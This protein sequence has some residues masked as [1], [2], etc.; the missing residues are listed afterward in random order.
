MY[1][2]YILL[3]AF[4]LL[5]T[6]AGEAQNQPSYTNSNAIPEKPLPGS[7]IRWRRN[8]SAFCVRLP[9]RILQIKKVK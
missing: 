5:M 9:I 1:T 4:Y 6:P 2:R 8:T 7:R 3:P